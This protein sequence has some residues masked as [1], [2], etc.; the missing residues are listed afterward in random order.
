[1][2]DNQTLLSIVEFQNN[3]I[4]DL[5][6][7]LEIKDAQILLFA[8]KEIDREAKNERKPRKKV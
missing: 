8:S 6:C 2:K 1:M 4:A 5:K 3:I 7:E